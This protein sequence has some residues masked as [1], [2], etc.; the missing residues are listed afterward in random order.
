MHDTV[1]FMM[2]VL[3]DAGFGWEA[4]RERTAR[5]A[6]PCARVARP[7]R[8]NG[9][10]YPSRPIW[11]FVCGVADAPRGACCAVRPVFAVGVV[12]R[13][14]QESEDPFPFLYLCHAVTERVLVESAALQGALLEYQGD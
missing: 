3:C 14:A 2:C 4:D 8:S 12:H 7:A 6:W 13:V 9:Q 10:T 11:Y 1:R 5:V